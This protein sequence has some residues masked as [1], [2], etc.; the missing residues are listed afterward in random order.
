MSSC[1]DALKYSRR[2]IAN[3]LHAQVN[4]NN[5]KS[6]TCPFDVGQSDSTAHSRLPTSL[7]FLSLLLHHFQ[8]FIPFPP[9]S[10]PKCPSFHLFSH[11]PSLYIS[12]ASLAIPVASSSSSQP[13]ELTKSTR[14]FTAAE[15][16]CDE[17]RRI[18][19]FLVNTYGR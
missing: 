8:I 19:L 6:G 7:S 16:Y 18:F 2:N 13:Q 10:P 12:I 1:G 3:H 4:A 17:Q 5:Q 15:Q 11:L 9:L 14:S